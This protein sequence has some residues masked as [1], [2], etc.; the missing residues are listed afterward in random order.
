MLPPSNSI[1]MEI[2][3]R[4]KPHHSSKQIQF[5]YKQIKRNQQHPSLNRKRRPQISPSSC[6]NKPSPSISL[7]KQFPSKYL[8]RDR[9]RPSGRCRSSFRLCGRSTSRLKYYGIFSSI[10]TKSAF[11]SARFL[12]CPVHSTKD[13]RMSWWCSSRSIRSWYS[14]P[15]N[16]TWILLLSMQP[17][18]SMISSTER[19]KIFANYCVMRTSWGNSAWSCIWAWT[20][21]TWRETSWGKLCF[22]L[23]FKF[24]MT[25]TRR[26]RSFIFNLTPWR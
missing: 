7:N 24:C 22:Y 18:T 23:L 12:V 2:K 17:R 6:L 5:R 26:S 21:L 1:L 15:W 19:F 4:S 9:K 25:I 10:A 3:S 20:I 16:W 11:S 8:P 14:R 13:F